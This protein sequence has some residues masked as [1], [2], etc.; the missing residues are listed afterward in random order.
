MVD[1]RLAA[2]PL[3]DWERTQANVSSTQSDNNWAAFGDASS[4]PAGDPQSSSLDDYADYAAE[5]VH[6]SG[7]PTD[8][9]FGDFD[10]FGASS[11]AHSGGQEQD[12][13]ANFG[14]FGDALQ[15]AVSQED[16]FAA[17]DA[18]GT[19][20]G[21]TTAVTHVTA[22]AAMPGIRTHLRAENEGD[23]GTRC[24]HSVVLCPYTYT[25]IYILYIEL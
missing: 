5:P 16:D 1:V 20:T 15:D 8:D 14:D 11:T 21:D 3:T 18:F 24:W 4:A 7:A 12:S 2:S 22:V 25:H 9:A 23:A 6:K 19:S 17:F 13:F 10:A